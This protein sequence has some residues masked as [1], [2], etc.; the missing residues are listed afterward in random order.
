LV[1]GDPLKD[2]RVLQDKQPF[3]FI[4]KG[5]VRYRRLH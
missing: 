4:M 5:G 2:V 3:A 1:E